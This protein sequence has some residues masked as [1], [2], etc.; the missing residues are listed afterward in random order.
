[1]E[2]WVPIGVIAREHYDMS[3]GIEDD[4]REEEMFLPIPHSWVRVGGALG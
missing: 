2:W 3:C 4:L 1:M